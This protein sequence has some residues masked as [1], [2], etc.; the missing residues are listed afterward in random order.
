[1]PIK[2]SAMFPNRARRRSPSSRPVA[3]HLLAAMPSWND[4]ETSSE[5]E[6]EVVSMDTGL[7]VSS[8]PPRVRVRVRC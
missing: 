3:V 8:L 6:C 5:E 4:E 1:M 2:F 7:M